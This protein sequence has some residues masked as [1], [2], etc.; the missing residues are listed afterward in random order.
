MEVKSHTGKKVSKYSCILL[1]IKYI[2]STA[3]VEYVKS[4]GYNLLTVPE[5]GQVLESVGFI[6]VEAKDMTQEFIGILKREV[7]DFSSRK[8]AI[9]K[10]FSSKDFDY[11]VNGWNDKVKRC[12]DGDQVWGYFLAKKPYV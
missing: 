2:C 6:E 10:E 5:Y 7:A 12:S 4:R 11:I 8:D 3:F 9:I 1:L